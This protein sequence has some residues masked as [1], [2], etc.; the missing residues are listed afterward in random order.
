MDNKQELLEDTEK[1]SEDVEELPEEDFQEIELSRNKKIILILSGILSYILFILILFPYSSFLRYFLTK[2]IEAVKIDYTELQ[3]DFPG[4][5]IIRDLYVSN[6]KDFLLIG[7]SLKIETNL[8]HIINLR[9]NGNISLTKGSLKVSEVPI[10]VTNLKIKINLEN[11]LE[12]LNNLSKFTGEINGKIEKIQLEELWGP[13]KTF[14]LPEDQK[15][16]E[17]LDFGI[18]FD[19]GNYNIKKFNLKTKLFDMNLNANGVLSNRIE[20]SSL[21]GEVCLIP[22]PKLEEL[23]PMIYSIYLGSGGSLGGKLCIK[24]NGMLSNLKFEPQN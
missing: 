2:Y 22:N 6:E 3:Y 21:S 16:V 18:R 23:N 9:I 10:E 5:F 13:L 12:E 1:D 15:I 4:D 14:T 8:I 17:D 20:N 11:S 7:E 19:R 24:I